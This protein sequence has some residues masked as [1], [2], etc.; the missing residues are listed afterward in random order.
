M[1]NKIRKPI[2]TIGIKLP[3]FVK[4]DFYTFDYG[5]DYQGTRTYT[6]TR[7]MD[8]FIAIF[9]NSGTSYGNARTI[10]YSVSGGVS[11]SV[12]AEANEPYKGTYVHLL[13]GQTI[14]LT[15]SRKTD[16]GVNRT[17]WLLECGE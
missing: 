13:S 11:G 4:L 6:A 15:W 3:N 7:E 1:D 2:S 10:N 16:S 8:V 5:T 12:V 9:T 17:W 14:T